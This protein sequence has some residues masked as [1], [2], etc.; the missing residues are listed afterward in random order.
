[1]KKLIERMLYLIFPVEQVAWFLE[2]GVRTWSL[3]NAALLFVLLFLLV[4]SDGYFQIR[5]MPYFWTTNRDEYSLRVIL[6]TIVLIIGSVTASFVK[7]P[8]LKLLSGLS[9]LGS[10]TFFIGI[11]AL[12]YV[13]SPPYHDSMFILIP[14]ALANYII[15]LHVCEDARNDLMDKGEDVNTLLS[16]RHE[17]KK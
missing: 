9:L 6:V 12:Y 14:A 16:K 15:G 8:K 4:G 7:S 1:M 3:I 13:D 17:C 11:L 10:F 5:D 2:N